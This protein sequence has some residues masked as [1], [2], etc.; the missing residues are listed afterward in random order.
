MSSRVKGMGWDSDAWRLERG[1]GDE[2]PDDDPAD[3]QPVHRARHVIHLVGQ[4][5][6][7]G[8]GAVADE[9]GVFDHAT[10]PKGRSV[11]ACLSRYVP[12]P[13]R[14]I[15]RA[16]PRAQTRDVTCE[17]CFSGYIVRRL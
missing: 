13:R 14:S 15:V 12:A 6:E 8:Q 9:Q 2:Q 7:A 4:V 16:T 5:A 11:P 1:P 3:Q 17:R 10:P